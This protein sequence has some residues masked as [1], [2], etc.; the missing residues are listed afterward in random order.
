MQMLMPFQSFSRGEDFLVNQYDLKL[1]LCKVKESCKCPYCSP[2]TLVH[3]GH[4]SL[5]LSICCLY[6]SVFSPLSSRAPFQLAA[7]YEKLECTEI[8]KPQSNQQI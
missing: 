6:H 8:A 3:S 7:G 1:I 2:I 5:V 4:K